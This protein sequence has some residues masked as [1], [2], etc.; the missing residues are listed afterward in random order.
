MPE[1]TYPLLSALAPVLGGVGIGSL[2]TVVAQHWVTKKR[3]HEQRTFT[4]KKAAYTGLLQALHDCVVNPSDNSLK[5]F[6]LAL[7]HVH[8]FGSP[9]SIQYAELLKNTA[10]N[11]QE[12]DLAFT[13]LLN[14]MRNDLGIV[15]TRDN[16]QSQ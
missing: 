5:K 7:A 15:Q 9:E 3:E 6:A 2:L 10:P 13:E 8:I 12:R 11:S 1:A 14:A 4:E 16:K